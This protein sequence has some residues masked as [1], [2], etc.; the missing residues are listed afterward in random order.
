MKTKLISAIALL[1]VSAAS[2]G[3]VYAAVTVPT[4]PSCVNP[5]GALKVSYDSGSHG[6]IGMDG[7][8]TGSDKVF[9]V[10][11]YDQLI[12]CFCPENGN[13]IQTNWYAANQLSSTDIEYLKKEGW[14]Y[15]AD[16]KA[17]GLAEIPYVAKNYDYN[18]KPTSN[19]T[20][21]PTPNTTVAGVLSLASTGN[22]TFL[23]TLMLLGFASL[24]TG[25]VLRFKK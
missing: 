22:V 6:I 16:G 8:K 14:L 12:Q 13:G 5:Q 21:T 3:Q 23:Y 10:S 20:P 11:D 15:A 4:F 2:V 19:S 7:L 25:L 17:W 18:C 24:A 9:K 1:T